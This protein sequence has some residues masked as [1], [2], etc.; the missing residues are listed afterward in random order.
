MSSERAE[1]LADRPD[2]KMYELTPEGQQRAAD[3]LA[4]V[5]WPKPDLAEFHLQSWW[6]RAAA[7][8][9]DPISIVAATPG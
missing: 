8:L 6:P 1:G 2:R 9:A 7:G 3:W 5:S 4:E